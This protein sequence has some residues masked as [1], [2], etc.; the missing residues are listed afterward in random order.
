MQR[1]LR[2]LA[3]AGWGAALLV[4]PRVVRERE[5]HLNVD[6]GSL[7][8]AR[9]LGVPHLA[10]AALSGVNPSPEV[11]A[12]G[13]WVDAAHPSTALG[14]PSSTAAATPGPTDAPAAPRRRGA[15]PHC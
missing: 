8:V 6:P 3:R 14:S 7:L 5:H 4:A 15:D 12:I 13:V 2:E 11:L 10:Q 9:V 1:R